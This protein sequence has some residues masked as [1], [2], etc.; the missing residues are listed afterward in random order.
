MDIFWR[1]C[2]RRLFEYSDKRRNC[3]KWAISPFATMFSSFSHRLVVHSI[4]YRDFL[5]FDKN[6]QSHLLQNCCMRERVKHIELLFQ[7]KII[8]NFTFI[9]RDFPFVLLRCFQNGLLH[10]CFIWE[11]IKVNILYKL[12]IH[13]HLGLHP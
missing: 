1:L 6:V 8:N 2:S 12:I 11:R 5:I 13:S 9:Y 4:I 3:L 7:L 10:I